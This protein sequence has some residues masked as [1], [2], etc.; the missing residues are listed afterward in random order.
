MGVGGWPS[1]GSADWSVNIDE[2]QIDLAI[3]RG[4]PTVEPEE[5]FLSQEYS[6]DIPW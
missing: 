4:Y 5:L 2:E 3:I 1:I 6:C